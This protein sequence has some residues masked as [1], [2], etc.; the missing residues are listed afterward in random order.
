M[1]KIEEL[2]KQTTSTNFVKSYPI[3]NQLDI[4]GSSLKLI[5]LVLSYKDNGNDFF[6]K[7]SSIAEILNIKIQSTKDLVC[8]LKRYGYLTTIHSPNFNG[9]DGG[10]STTLIVDEDFIIKQLYKIPATEAV[11]LCDM[12]T[13]AKREPEASTAEEIVIPQLKE[14]ITTEATS[15]T[16]NEEIQ[17]NPTKRNQLALILTIQ[18]DRCLGDTFMLRKEISYKEIID[19]ILDETYED[20]DELVEYYGMAM[21]GGESNIKYMTN[22]NSRGLD[23]LLSQQPVSL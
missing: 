7:Y 3:L 8:K 23:K 4:S 17:F 6:M 10:S 5:E 20:T 11:S 21:D 16:T 22:L 12:K 9:V 1:N 15:G 19:A 2:Q 18:Q 13:S 14:V